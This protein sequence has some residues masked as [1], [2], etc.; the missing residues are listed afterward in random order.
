MQKIEILPLAQNEA[1]MLFFFFSIWSFILLC[2]PQDYFSAFGI[3]R[4]A[5]TF[6][7]LTLIAYFLSEKATENIMNSK[8]FKLYLLFVAIMIVGIPFSFYRRASFEHVLTYV[9]TMPLFF[10]LF[11][12]LATSIENLRSLLFTYCCGVAVYAVYILAFGKLSGE[13]LYFGTMFD[14]NDIVFF[15]ISFFTFNLLFI[16]KDNAAPKRI[17][18]IVNLMIGLVVIVKTGSRG[19]LVAF[20]AVCSYLLFVKTDTVKISFIAK[21][22][23]VCLVILSLMP[24]AINSER[25]KTIL[26]VQDD[27]NMTDET[28]RIAI[29]KIGIRMMFSHPLA[30]VGVSCFNEGVGRD[31]VQRGLASAKWQSAH[32]SIIQVGAETG[33]AGLVVFCLMSVKVFSITRKVKEKSRSKELIEISEMTR[34]GFIGHFLSSMFLSQAYSVYWVFYIALSAVLHRMLEKE[35]C[36]E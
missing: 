13:R 6:G 27:Y 10:F 33:L 17:L 2:R 34:A 12:Q 7:F 29:W 24:F 5:I 1:K 8:Q 21:I 11:Y 28:G 32:N 14:P 31:R 9:C 22:A 30:G 4:P 19:G 26:D 35:L 3:V 18:A 20:L 16:A 36:P 15:L 23:L 25:Y